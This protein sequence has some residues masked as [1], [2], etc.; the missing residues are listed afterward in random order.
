MNLIEFKTA[1]ELKKLGFAQEGESN[2]YYNKQGICMGANEWRKSQFPDY[3][4][5]TLSELVEACGKE[6]Y[7]LRRLKDGSWYAWPNKM[8]RMGEEG[9]SPEQAVARLWIVLQDKK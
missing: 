9:N 2:D 5:P 6:F 8:G 4:C 7:D 1:K 3:Y